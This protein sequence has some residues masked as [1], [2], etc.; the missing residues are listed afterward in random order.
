MMSD[1]TNTNRERDSKKTFGR[2]FAYGESLRKTGTENFDQDNAHVHIELSVKQ[3]SVTKHIAVLEHPPYSQD[4]TPYDFYLF[5]KVKNASKGTQFQ[6]ID[7]VKAKM[8]DLL[9]VVT[10]NELQHC[11]E[12][13]K[14]RM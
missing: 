3:F 7:E 4:L 8:V 6:Y 5:I 1:I 11:F 13:W 2:E 14:T 9:K 10:P 12:R